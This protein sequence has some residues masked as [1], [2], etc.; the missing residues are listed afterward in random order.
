MSSTFD[1]PS[2]VVAAWLANQPGD[3]I[4]LLQSLRN[5]MLSAMPSRMTYLYPAGCWSPLSKNSPSMIR[6]RNLT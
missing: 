3:K 5:L 4:E 6:R 2:P 1:N